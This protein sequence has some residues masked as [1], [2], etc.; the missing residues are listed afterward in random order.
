MMPFGRIGMTRPE[1]F[2]KQFAVYEQESHTTSR[3]RER[4][5]K[6]KNKATIQCIL[7]TAKP[8]ERE[9][10]SQLGI[11]VTHSLI[12]R[13]APLAKENDWLA[14]LKN[15]KEARCFRVQA[16]HNKGEMDIDTVYYCEERSDLHELQN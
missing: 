12:Q 8:E 14:L 7:S 5:D 3:G 11:T 13:G 16:V 6:P 2:P 4:L 9:R 1:N 15:G 10:Y